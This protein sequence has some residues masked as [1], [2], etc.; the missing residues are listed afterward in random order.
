MKT[1][2]RRI[3]ILNFLKSQH[4]HVGTEEILQHLIDAGYLDDQ[5][6]LDRSQF[7]L[8]QRDLNFLLGDELEEDEFEN[9]FGLSRE[10]GSRKSLLWQLEPYQSLNYD[11][12]RMPAFMA[13]ALSVTQKHLQQVLPTSTQ[14]EL[15]RVFSRAE[16][17]LNKR[18]Q[19]LSPLHYQRLTQSVEFFQRG[20]KL[21]APDFDMAILDTIYRAILMAKRLRFDYQSGN[22][23][24]AY[25][26]HPY[27]VAIMLPKIY[28]VGIKD[29]DID[30]SGQMETFRSF[31]IHKIDSIELSPFSNKVPEDFE[32]KR[33]LEEGNMDVLIDYKDHHAYPLSLEINTANSGNLLSDL[34]ESP[35]SP[36]QTLTQIETDTWQLTAGVKRTIQ[37]RNWLIA[38][39]PAA[40]ILEPTIIQ[41]DLLNYL[42]SIQNRYSD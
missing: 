17:K 35:I 38:L 8:I 5:E 22:G 40:R 37:L 18:D 33:Y 14:H 34:R 42:G 28:L 11:F 13:L 21:E 7:R 32:L 36:D 6:R 25:E 24:K 1:F 16:D 41:Q 12:E 9:E 2:L 15:Q 31:L 27:G 4:R 19:K 20:Q 3:E 10:K 26:L 39:G 29:E 30:K 23:T